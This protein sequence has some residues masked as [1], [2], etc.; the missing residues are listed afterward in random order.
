MPTL[1][2]ERALRQATGLRL[3]A[4]I[5]EA[6]RGALAGPVVAAAVILPLDAPG[7]LESLREVNDSKRLTPAARARLWE[8]VTTHA[9]AFGVGSADA[10]VVDAAGI[11]SATKQAMVAAVAQL[12]PAAEA[13]L[14]DGRI[15]L[16]HLPHPQQALIRGDSLSLSIAAASILAKVARDRAM[17]AL[18][19]VYP[20]YGFARHKGYGTA[21]HLAALAR[22]GPTPIHRHSFAPIRQTLL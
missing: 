2:Y 10:A 13:L 4:G 17:V 20:Q 8:V 18:D 12:R 15:R 9:L 5:D 19:A 16:A 7:L 14:I 1:D 21:R 6:G 22:C 3:I 11:M